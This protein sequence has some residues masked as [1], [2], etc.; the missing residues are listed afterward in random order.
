MNKIG[1]GITINQFCGSGDRI[2]VSMRSPE[3]RS[4]IFPA[5][6]LLFSDC[7][8]VGKTLKRLPFIV[9]NLN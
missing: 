2:S 5:P 6:D 4:D 9:I 7:E 1:C 3:N 8:A